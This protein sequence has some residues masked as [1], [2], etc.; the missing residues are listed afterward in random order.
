MVRTKKESLKESSWFGEPKCKL[1]SKVVQFFVFLFIFIV[2][3]YPCLNSTRIKD[4]LW[5][6]DIIESTSTF[7][8]LINSRVDMVGFMD[9]DKVFA[10]RNAF[11]TF[12]I[13]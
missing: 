5:I 2:F 9:L 7:P 13:A 3:F 6:E 4:V 11:S 8:F 1:G 10:K 12:P